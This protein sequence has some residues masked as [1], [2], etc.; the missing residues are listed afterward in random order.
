M[1][2]SRKD[3]LASWGSVFSSREKLLKIEILKLKS[4]LEKAEKVIKS[5]YTNEKTTTLKSDC[6]IKAREYF[7]DK[8]D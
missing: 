8:D 1:V 5:L 3:T 6:W 4:Q 2:A 7:K